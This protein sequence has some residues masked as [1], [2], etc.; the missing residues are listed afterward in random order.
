MLH[1]HTSGTTGKSLDLWRSRDAVRA[2]YAL[3]LARAR[4]WYGVSR[5]DRWAMVGGQLVTP[6]EQRRPP[7]WVWNLALRQLYMS[8]YHLSPAFAPSYLDALSRY[9]V[10][11][12]SGYTSSL[13]ALAQE[14]L[15]LGRRDLRMTVAITNAEPVFRYQRETIA[16]A[17]QCPVRETYCMSEMALAAS[18]CEAGALH[19]SPEVGFLEV[20]EGND[21]VPDGTVGDMVCTGLLNVDMPL[22]RYR[23]GDRGALAKDGSPCPCGR[24]L[25][26][27]A[28]IEGRL[29]DILYTPDGR[30]IGRLDPVFKSNL[31]LREAQIVQEALNR[32]RVRY[33][34]A[35]GFTPG[36]EQTIVEGIRAR[37][38]AVDVILEEVTEVPRAANGKFRAV[39]CNLRP[40]EKEAALQ[41]GRQAP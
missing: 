9:Q 19:L 24:K 13:Y 35:P 25:P 40:A 26:R 21:S 3:S 4:G 5:S 39:I 34:P 28:Q 41:R 22:I 6:V 12:L 37:M 11:Y 7:F 36:D 38:G 33:A 30:R 15:R 1:E 16:E 23:V 14:V 20:L 29:D 18:E 32:I 31:H 27:L 2:L 10:A 17:F 8:S